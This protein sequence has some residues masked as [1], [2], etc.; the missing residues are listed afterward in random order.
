MAARDD[1]N[2][3]VEVRFATKDDMEEML[4]M[5][6]EMKKSFFK[7]DM[8]REAM[9]QSLMYNFE[10]KK[11]GYHLVAYDAN[12]PTGKLLGMMSTMITTDVWA[13]GKVV[14]G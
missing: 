1:D 7:M 8:D 14:W 11:L 4:D 10:N 6:I 12:N 3:D 13:G 5:Q 2:I 9:R